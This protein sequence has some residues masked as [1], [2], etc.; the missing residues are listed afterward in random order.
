MESVLEGFGMVWGVAWKG[1]SGDF[2]KD[3]IKKS[4]FQTMSS[5]NTSWSPLA[6]LLDPLETV[7]E[8][9]GRALEGSSEQQMWT[10]SLCQSFRSERA[11]FFDT[12]SFV[13]VS[14][15]LWKRC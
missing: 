14:H 8:V 2:V 7:L 9:S 15:L 4:S 5:Q 3:I 1:K 10:L 12:F 11:S 6:R 13:F